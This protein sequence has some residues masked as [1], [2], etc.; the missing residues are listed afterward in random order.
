MDGIW[1]LRT[2]RLANCESRNSEAP[3]RTAAFVC[4]ITDTI[5]IIT[6]YGLQHLYELIIAVLP[7]K[8]DVGVVN[9]SLAMV[10]QRIFK[11]A[12]S[13]L[14]RADPPAR[15]LLHKQCLRA[16][17]IQSS[18]AGTVKLP[19]IDPNA[20]SIVETITPKTLIS[21]EELVFGR[22]FT[23]MAH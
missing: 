4:Q 19:G 9:P 12:T 10:R 8:S 11:A 14:S 16:Y 6:L 2:D 1:I 7:K 21:P 22:N 18:E 23:G 5:L 13:R 17:S 3:E 20:V 15:P